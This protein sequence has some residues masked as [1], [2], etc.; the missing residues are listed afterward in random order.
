MLKNV[1]VHADFKEIILEAKLRKPLKSVDSL[2]ILRQPSHDSYP[3]H[4]A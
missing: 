3:Q 2:K 4:I 1:E